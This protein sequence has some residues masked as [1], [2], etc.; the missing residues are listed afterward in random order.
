MKTKVLIIMILTVF[1][2]IASLGNAQEGTVRGRA[3]DA[4]GQPIARRHL[5]QP[6]R[7]HRSLRNLDG[8]QRLLRSHRTSACGLPRTGLV[9]E[10]ISGSALLLATRAS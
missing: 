3:T 7:H 6:R 1:G 9:R 2:L 10:G 5:D 8:Y 4:S